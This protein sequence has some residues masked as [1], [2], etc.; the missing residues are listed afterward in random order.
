VVP[1]TLVA[2]GRLQWLIYIFRT[3]TETTQKSDSPT[4][5]RNGKLVKRRPNTLHCPS[6]CPRGLLLQTKQYN[7]RAFESFLPTDSNIGLAMIILYMYIIIIMY[8]SRLRVCVRVF[9][10][11][12]LLI[13]IYIYNYITYIYIDTICLTFTGPQFYTHARRVYVC[14]I[15]WRWPIHAGLYAAIIVQYDYKNLYYL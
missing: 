11:V 2:P 12:E 3:T 9:V 1:T 15:P 6:E 13:N 14:R 4:C 7:W 5:F 10:C 8:S